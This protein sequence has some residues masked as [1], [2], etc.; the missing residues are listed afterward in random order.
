MF[1]RLHSTHPLL[2][3][4]LLAASPLS[5]RRAV[6]AVAS[7]AVGRAGIEPKL[8]QSVVSA[9]DAQTELG[10]ELRLR[11]DALRERAD[12]EYV[13]AQEALA[14]GD[15]LPDGALAAFHRARALQALTFALESVDGDCATEVVYEALA[16]GAAEEE[17][18]AAVTSA[19]DADE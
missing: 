9:I 8:A 6:R 11:V 17:V 4:A 12:D 5:R 2:A 3:G 13:Q 10:P 19:L 18:I 1:T 15:S 16:S 7:V 14:P